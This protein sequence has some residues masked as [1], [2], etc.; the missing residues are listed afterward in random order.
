MLIE[1]IASGAKTDI[2]ELKVKKKSKLSK[3][4]NTIKRQLKNK[5]TI[6]NE[7]DRAARFIQK[8]WF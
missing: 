1:A 3:E 2:L 6:Q 7:A 5:M 4:I 8:I